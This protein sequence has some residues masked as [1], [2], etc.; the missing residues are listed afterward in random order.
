MLLRLLLE[1]PESP[2]R[3]IVTTKAGLEFS[4]FF[5]FFA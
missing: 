5:F 3:H 1:L 4:F 2:L